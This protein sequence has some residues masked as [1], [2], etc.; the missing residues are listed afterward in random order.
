M[1]SNQ[2]IKPARFAC[3]TR[4]AR[5]TCSRLI[6]S[7]SSLENRDGSDRTSQRFGTE[8]TG[9]GSDVRSRLAEHAL[10]HSTLNVLQAKE[11]EYTVLALQPTGRMLVTQDS[12]GA[13]DPVARLHISSR[14]CDLQLWHRAANFLFFRKGELGYLSARSG[15]P[16]AALSWLVVRTPRATEVENA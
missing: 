9:A 4:K 15:S 2:R 13:A 11:F 3:S 10:R 7:V 1:K 16:S 6:R 8:P 14:F 5:C 12:I